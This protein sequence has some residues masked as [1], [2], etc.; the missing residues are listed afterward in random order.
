MAHQTRPVLPIRTLLRIPVPWVFLLAYLLG[1]GLQH[2]LPYPRFPPGAR[3][4]LNVTGIVLWLLAVII[5]G[6]A[7]FLFHHRRTTT[8][9]GEVSRTLVL[10]GPYRLS[11][12][13][14]YVGLVL[15]YVGEM[16]CQALVWPLLTLVL[17]VAYVQGI[18][19]P[20]EESRLDATF[21][22]SYAQYRARVRRWI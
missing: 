1:W 11:R 6:S 21:G 22:E 9:P 8:T 19:I 3:H 18:V 13:P 16:C 12:N 5:A 10:D 17:T 7:L 4:I 15:A 2:L 20:L 14:M